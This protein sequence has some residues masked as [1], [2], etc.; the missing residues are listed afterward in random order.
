MVEV[1]MV[2][3]IFNFPLIDRLRTSGRTSSGVLR[4]AS[5]GDKCESMEGNLRI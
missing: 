2:C 1:R 3:V 5:H 4:E